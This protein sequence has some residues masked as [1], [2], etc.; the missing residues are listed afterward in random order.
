MAGESS[1]ERSETVR[2]TSGWQLG[3]LI[4][5]RHKCDETR[6]PTMKCV[7]PEEE[8]FVAW[9]AATLYSMITCDKPRVQLLSSNVFQSVGDFKMDEILS[10]RRKA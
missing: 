5:K 8:S 7:L 1:A 6:I 9:K 2:E 4:A 3:K 10:I